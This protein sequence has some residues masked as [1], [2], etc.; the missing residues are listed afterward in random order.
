MLPTSST[1]SVERTVS[2]AND[3]ADDRLVKV[4]ITIDFGTGPVAG[5]YRLTDLVPSGLSP[6]A[7]TAA[8]PGTEDEDHPL[9]ENVNWPYLASGQQ[10][11]WCAS[12]ED[13]NHTY[14]YAARVVSPG[15]YRWEPAVLQLELDPRIGAST[16]ATTF[17]IR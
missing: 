9:P 2:P 5:C 6:V 17:T 16:P 3:A 4:T 10:V 11:S 7:R 12:P 15:T 14:V 1:I 8:W 13:T